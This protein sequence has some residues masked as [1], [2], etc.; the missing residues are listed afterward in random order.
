MFNAY[1]VITLRSYLLYKS[2]FILLT[3]KTLGVVD[4]F[5]V[6]INVT[7]GESIGIDR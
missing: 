3:I 2:H 7:K 1:M 4:N 5:Y 6:C